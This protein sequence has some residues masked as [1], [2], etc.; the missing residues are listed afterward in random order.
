M[1]VCV[2][3]L[4]L[5]RYVNGNKVLVLGLNMDVKLFLRGKLKVIIFFYIK[6]FINLI[7]NVKNVWGGGMDV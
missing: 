6:F 7:F 2:I 1:Y 3:D 4:I 5:W